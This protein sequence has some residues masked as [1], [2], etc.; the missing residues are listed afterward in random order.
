MQ[1]LNEQRH[2]EMIG[3]CREGTDLGKKEKEKKM[4]R[5]N[6]QRQ[7]EMIGKRRK[8]M[9]DGQQKQLVNKE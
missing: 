3:K 7:I 1:R 6:E 9:I 5:L 8:I 2:T 4:Q